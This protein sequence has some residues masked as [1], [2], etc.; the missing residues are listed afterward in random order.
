MNEILEILEKDA[1]TT[2]E[3]MAKMTGMKV[4]AVKGVIKKSEKDGAK[5]RK[6]GEPEG[7]GTKGNPERWG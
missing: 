4:Q 5:C 7:I 3:E 2:P 6:N 1:R